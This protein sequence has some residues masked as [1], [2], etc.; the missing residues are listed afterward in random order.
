MGMRSHAISLATLPRGNMFEEQVALV[1]EDLPSPP[2][3]TRPRTQA[4]LSPLL[5]EWKMTL[6]RLLKKPL[7]G[8]AARLNTLRKKGLDQQKRLPQ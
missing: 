1:D 7:H 6:L 3:L 2:V 5:K 4:L 8:C